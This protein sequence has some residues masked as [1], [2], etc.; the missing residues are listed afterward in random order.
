MRHATHQ[1]KQ[2]SLGAYAKCSF[3]AQERIT[4]RHICCKPHLKHAIKL[5]IS[6]ITDSV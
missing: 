3:P 4:Q 6:I 2:D 1:A 5:Y